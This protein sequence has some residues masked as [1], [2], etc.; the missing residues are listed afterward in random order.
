MKQGGQPL[1]QI[2]VHVIVAN[3]LANAA[4]FATNHF[5]HVTSSLARVT[6]AYHLTPATRDFFLPTVPRL[7]QHNTHRKRGKLPNTGPSGLLQAITT[8]TL[9]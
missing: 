5:N 6:A 9:V 7:T 8:F 3:R 2:F 4:I 1:S